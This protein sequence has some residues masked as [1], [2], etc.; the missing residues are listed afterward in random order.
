ME[1]YEQYSRVFNHFDED[2]DGK[3][4]AK[5]LRECVVSLGSTEIS[6]EESRMAVEM[7]D[8]DGDGLLC[9]E[10]FIKLLE[11]NGDEGSE[12]ERV[13]ELKEAFKM[14]ELDGKGYINAKSL[15]KM[16]G[17]LLG[18]SKSIDECKKMIACFDINGDG[19]L[20]FDEFKIM[21]TC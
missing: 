5:E 14:Y 10:E 18:E 7:M 9:L 11:G 17:R 6:M 19:V 20:S 3:V 15:K 8:A 16:L 4:S 21:M 12:E 1:K 2:G 13:K